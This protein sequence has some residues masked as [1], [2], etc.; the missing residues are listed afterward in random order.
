MC[1][2]LLDG[3]AWTLSEVAAQVGVA[4]STASEHASLLVGAGLLREERPGRHRYLRLAGGEFAELLEELAGAAAPP[5]GLRQVRASAELAA[6]RTCY[7]HLAGQ[8]GVRLYAAMGR[9][10]LLDPGGLTDLGR[11]W[12]ADL[13]GPEMLNCSSRRPLVRECL[14]WTERLPH[15][16]GRLGASLTAFFFEEGWLQRLP[17]SRAITVTARGEEALAEQFDLTGALSS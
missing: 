5:R 15:L 12:F 13:V 16:G 11:S 8:L 9:R 1:L 17:V 6:A 2:A 3:R 4:T 7:D 10:G 14:D